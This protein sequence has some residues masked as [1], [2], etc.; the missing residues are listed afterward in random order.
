MK[1]IKRISLLLAVVLVFSLSLSFSAFAHDSIKDI[2]ENNKIYATIPWEYELSVF[3]DDLAYRHENGN[4]IEFCVDENKLAPEGITALSESQIK[5]VFEHFYLNEGDLE[6]LN[7]YIIICDKVEKMSANGYNC[8]YI[9]GKYAFSEDEIDSEFAYY[10]HAAIFATKENI[11]TVAFESYEKISE[12]FDTDLPGALSGIVFNGTHFEG[13]KPEL[14]A[15]HDFSNSPDYNEVV[16][17]AQG[18]L[19]GDIFEDESMVTI[20][21]VV[22]VLFTIVPTVV[23]AIIAIVLIVKYFKNKKKLQRYELTYGSVPAY[24]PVQQNYGTYGYNQPVNQ[25]YQSSVNP[26]YQQ[27]PIDQ[28]VQQTPSYVTNAVNNLATEQP[29]QPAQE[30]LSPEEQENQNSNENNF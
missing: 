17:G 3:G 29:T 30:I 22:I 18:A 11:F 1:N 25:P 16:T 26:A 20:V 9:S 8:Y 21:A 15:D 14:Y 24:N 5:K 4:Y 23:V 10:F 2:E 6:S 27:N 12:F 19:F 13:D 7:D 28:N